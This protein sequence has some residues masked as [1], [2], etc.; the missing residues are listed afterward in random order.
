MRN[1]L[2]Y[3]HTSP[4]G[5]RYVGITGTSAEQRWS[6][7]SG[8][9]KNF[10]FYRAI[11]KYGWDSFQHTILFEGLT[12][13][14]AKSIEIRLIK[15]W[16]LTDKQFGY[17]L[18]EGGDGSFTIESRMKMSASRIGNK[19]RVGRMIPKEQ[20]IKISNSLKAYYSTHPNPFKGK[21]HREET[22][23]KLRAREVTAETRARMRKNHAD[24]SGKANPSAKPVVQ[25]S[26]AGEIIKRYDYASQAAKELSLDLSSIIKCCRGKKKTCGGYRWA[27]D[28]NIT[29]SVK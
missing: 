29:E 10:Y 19:N 13:E 20:R 12:L 18:R 5:K 8:Y 25:L 17:N 11:Q 15:E 14:E 28:I 6:N 23:E 2:V 9:K 24:V 4:S 27:Y 21:H 26:L 3:C 16:N 1:Y 22:K 7:G